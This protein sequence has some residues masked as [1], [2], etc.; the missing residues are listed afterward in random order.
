MAAT[1][2]DHTRKRLWTWADDSCA[3][4]GCGARLLHANDAKDDE[5]VVGEECHII[6][7]ADDSRVARSPSSLSNEEKIRWSELLENRHG[8]ANLVLMCRIHARVI[9]DPAQSYSVGQIVAMKKAHEEEVDRRR[10]M[11][12]SGTGSEGST[13][14]YQ[15]ILLEDVGVWQQKATAALARI[16]AEALAWLRE[17]IGSPPERSRVA[18]LIEEWPARLRDGPPELAN[19]LVREAEGLAMWTEAANVWERL[20]VSEQPEKKAD[21]LTRAAIDA[22][23][24]G[25]RERQERLLVASEALDPSSVRVRLERL[26]DGLPP[27]DQ[28]EYLADL[29]TDDPSLASL[30]A[31]RRALAY[32]QASDLDGAEA[33]IKQAQKFEPDSIAVQIARVNFDLQAARIAL[34]SDRPFVVARVLAIY[35]K[36]LELRE[37]LVSMGRWEESGRLLMMA[38]DARS[39]LRD[40]DG[41]RDALE[42]ALPEEVLAPQGAAVLGDAAL[43]AGAPELALRF[44]QGLEVDDGLRR[45][46]ASARADIGG[47]DRAKALDEL[48]ELALSESEEAEAAA[49]ARL[50]LCMPPVL[51]PWNDE[52]AG[53]LE[54]GEYDRYAK[55][56]R[57]MALASHDPI[58]A[59][60]LA[61]DLPEEAWAA[62][63]RLRVAGGADD[64]EQ[65]IVAAKEFLGHSP[66]GMGRLLAARAMARAGELERAGEIALAVARDPNCPAIVRSDAFHVA[67]KTLADRGLWSPAGRTWEEWRDFGFSELPRFDGRISAWQVRVIHN[68]R[69]QASRRPSEPE[70][71]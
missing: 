56:L 10:R 37:R 14:V 7:K 42:R 34:A 2:S 1:I 18:A 54:G 4:T 3:F 20:A 70:Q 32:L 51:A 63:I 45:I 60:A 24:G 8:F 6:A 5:T 53:I 52:V 29:E 17:A 57:V 49:A 30:I 71:K 27:R 43:R 44:V 26:D 21:L 67:M 69:R 19:L 15:P 59:K 48:E 22:S 50:V 62:E 35:D 23:I 33:E 38:A 39:L 25:E 66:D 55:G 58:A 47:L 11:T 36:A 16:D 40:L 31:A 64:Q 28:L 68:R 9:D 41:A 61:A 12:L 13:V 65:M 46:A